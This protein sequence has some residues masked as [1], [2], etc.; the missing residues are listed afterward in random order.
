MRREIYQHDQPLILTRDCAE[1]QAYRHS[2]TSHVVYYRH[3]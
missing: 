1:K 2:F 3:S